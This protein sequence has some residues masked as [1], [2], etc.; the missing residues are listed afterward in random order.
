VVGAGAIGGNFGG[1]L[2][3]AGRDVSFLV[4]PAAVGLSIRS[5]FGDA[6]L[7]A[8]PTISEGAR[9]RRSIGLLSCKA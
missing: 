6:D 4:C 3:E 8:P 5:R 1:W 7:S 2:L 9:R